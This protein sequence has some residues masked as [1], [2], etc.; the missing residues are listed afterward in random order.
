[1][2]VKTLFS[3]AILHT[4]F[5][6]PQESWM[7]AGGSN[8]NNTANWSPP[9]VPNGVSVTVTFGAAIVAPSTV[10]LDIPVTFGGMTFNNAQSYTISPTGSNTFTLQGAPTNIT[11]TTGAH[12]ISVPI[13]LNNNL[14]VTQNSTGNLTL[15]GAISGTN[16]LTIQGAGTGH[17]VL[18]AGNLYTGGTTVTAGT[19]D[20]NVTA[21][22]PASGPL[23]ISGGTVNCN[24]ANTL[25]STGLITLSGGTLQLNDNSQ[26][27][28]PVA[29]TSNISL[30]VMTSTILTST[31]TSTT[32]YSGVISGAGG[33]TLAGSGGVLTFS[34][35]NTYSGGTII[36]GSTLT[37]GVNNALL[38]TGNLTVNS[39]GVFNL[40]NFNQ[41]VAALAG[42]GSIVLGSGNLTTATAVNSTFSGVISG[43]GTF[44]QAGISTLALTG[45]NTY[46]GGTTI[47]GGG[48]L[49]L[50]INNALASTGPVAITS[51]TLDMTPAASTVQ[52]IGPLSGTGNVNLGST[53]LTINSTASS[54]YGGVMS[55]LGSLIIAG[56]ETLTLTNNNTFSGGTTVNGG[57]L[58][59]GINNALL[60]T[61]NLTVNSPGIFNLAGFNQTVGVLSG[62]GSIT[63]GGGAFTVNTP[64]MMISNFSGIISQTGTLDVGGTGTLILTG[65]NT[66]SGPTNIAAGA[67]LQGTTTS[68]QG[69]INNSGN[70][71]FDQA[72]NGTFSGS[73]LGAGALFLN[74][75]GDVTLQGPQTEGSTT[76]NAGELILG[77]AANLIS[78]VTVAA[79]AALGTTG[80]GTITGNV[81]VNGT[82]ELGLGTINIVGNYTQAANST[83]DVEVTPTSSGF[84]PVTGTV[85]LQN[86]PTMDV[87]FQP[88]S[89]APSTLYTLIT[90]G[91]PVAGTFAAPVL[92]NPFFNGS[93]IYNGIAPGSVQLLLQ[94]AP[95][96]QVIKGG[97]AGAIA[98]CID[99]QAFPSESDLLPIIQTLIF[100]PVD[101]VKDALN[102]MQPSELK[103]L[104]RTEENNLVVVR[105]AVSQHIDNLNK[106]PCN[107]S[108]SKTY[109]WNVWSNFSGDFLRQDG[110]SENIGFD[111]NTAAAVGGVDIATVNNLFVGVAGAYDHSWLTW[112]HSKGHG[113]ISSVYGGPYLSWFDHRVFTNLSL[114][115]TWN[116]YH[117]SRHISFPSVNRHAKSHHTGRGLIAH[118]DL[119]VMMYPVNEMTFSP[120]AGLDYILLHESGF[121]EK[122]AGSIDMKVKSSIASLLRSEAGLKI[123]KC[124]IFT[125]NKWTHDLKLSW[126]HQHLFRGKHLHAKFKEVDCTYTVE[127]LEPSEDYFDVA[128]GLTGIFMKDKLA[129][130]LRYEGKFGDGIRDNTGYIQLSYRF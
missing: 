95:F 92:E 96:S 111:A 115:G 7:N 49:Q 53:Q 90:A 51:G 74:G 60:P 40:N 122:G 33:F 113:R 22:L 86:Q 78:P 63:L 24:I 108:M 68:L 19:L 119:G 120:I 21:A 66:Y 46:T 43:T 12:T 117:A 99:I 72:F 75:T 97:N 59:V 105:T 2:K 42:S 27:A 16:S 89:F 45:Q 48:T 57:T 103:A 20:C 64:A 104:T 56:P 128:T 93:L 82:T 39:P 35:P 4:A 52:A 124:A 13:L 30:G 101:K 118:F 98:E 81:T 15:A 107:Q 6:F 34:T 14:S 114:L 83:F 91:A 85:T 31:T 11:D 94:I 70:L 50:G 32:T 65:A 84:L 9:V 44:T 61:G 87:T 121:T 36:N 69:T 76:V 100:L 1:M 129:A 130:S 3:A 47:S 28:G 112:N 79:G 5:L 17:V 73:L 125:H 37:S 116:H 23:T 58:Q 38:P 102:E 41:N 110:Q 123:A 126:I 109:R 25:P 10:I 67:T 18:T 54:S 29:G 106:T 55:G 71:I 80:N 77:S 62:N 8:W 127:G 88:G 26:M